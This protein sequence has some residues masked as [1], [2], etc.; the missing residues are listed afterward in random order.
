MGNHRGEK[1][2]FTALERRRLAALKLL[3]LD[4]NQSEV[5]QR[6][7]MC[8][9]T[10]SRWA[11]AI[12]TQGDKAL[13]AAGQTGRKPRL[14]GQQRERLITRLLEGP[15]RLGYETPLW[16][17]N[18]VAH[19]IEEEFGFRYHAGHVWKLLRQLNWSPQ[20]PAGRAQ[21]TGH[22]PL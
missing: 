1:R 8:S 16:T 10:V 4:Y 9:Q 18:R 7:K 17:C 3:K 2:D 5:A 15:R 14:D 6:V 12:T 19:L 11:R 13:S 22:R 20:R 21:R